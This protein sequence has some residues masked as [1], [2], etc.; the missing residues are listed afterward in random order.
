MNIPWFVL[1]VVAV[2]KTQPFLRPYYVD[3]MVC[4]YAVTY[5]VWWVVKHEKEWQCKLDATSGA[6]KLIY[7]QS[8]EAAVTI[9][10]AF[11]S[12]YLLFDLVIPMWVFYTC[13]VIGVFGRLLVD[14]RWK[15]QMIQ[16]SLG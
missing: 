13:L 1:V 4:L 9:P 6:H 12:A 7:F 8:M 16:L 5:G 11:A 10:H 15:K 3:T 2:D 14:W